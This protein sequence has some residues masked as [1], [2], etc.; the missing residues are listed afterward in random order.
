M[1]RAFWNALR[2]LLLGASCSALALPTAPPVRES[3]VDTIIAKH[4]HARG[5]LAS[6]RAIQSL[7]RRGHFIVPGMG[8]R[9]DLAEWQGRG[10]QFRLDMTLQGL[11]QTQA[12]DGQQGW[13]VSP[14]EGRKDP[15]L[16][17]A[18]EVKDL[19]LQADFEFPFVDY[20]AKG[21]RVEIGP[22]E[23]IDG[24]PATTLVVYLAD[25]NQATYWM[26]PDTDMVIRAL[27]R[28][29]VRG[30]EDVTEIDY[31]DYR[32]VNGVW[33]PM[34]VAIGSKGSDPARRQQFVFETLVANPVV[35][36]TLYALPVTSPAAVGSHP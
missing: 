22:R 3:P 32:Q 14:F 11:T 19:R 29:T 30:A 4:V 12:T 17:S 18:D 25:G 33:M 28:E 2:I 31:G 23:D 8:M 21:H 35:P 5:G 1:H 7:E 9:L 10:G 13:Q 36:A 20:Q 27:I 26:D 24:T 34:A 15:S 16:L 6:L